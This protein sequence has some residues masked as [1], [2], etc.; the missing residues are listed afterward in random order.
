M[1]PDNFPLLGTV[2]GAATFVL[3]ALDEFEKIDLTP[4]VGFVLT[5]VSIINVALKMRKDR[6]A[7]FMY[8]GMLKAS[9]EANGMEVPEMPELK[10][11]AIK[12]P[13]ISIKQ[14]G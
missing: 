12:L 3:A 9:L 4:W 6:D 11:A 2:T 7:L 14:R 8:V 5:M 10:S 1:I 13:S